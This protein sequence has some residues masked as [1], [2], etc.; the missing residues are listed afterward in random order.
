MKRLTVAFMSAAAVS[1][2]AGCG[3]VEE[4]P[5]VPQITSVAGP[6][7]SLARLDG[8]V[9]R[10]SDLRGKVVVLDFWATWCPPCRA[11]I[12]GYIEMQRDLAGEDLVIVGVSLDEGGPAVVQEFADRMGINYELVMGDNEVVNGFGGVQVIPTTFLIDREG[13]VRH[14][15]E[16]MMSREDYESIVRE[17]L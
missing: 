9:L 2:W 6:E 14:R 11:E 1:L 7:W 4:V 13:Q 3:A 12:P 15:K 16:G 5:V 8:S 17:V 10:S